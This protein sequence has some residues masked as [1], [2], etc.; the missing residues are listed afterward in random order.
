MTLLELARTAAPIYAATGKVSAVLAAGSVGRGRAD[1]YSDLELD[2][3]WQVPPSD[4]D[5]LGVITALGA[6]LIDLWPFEQA[7]WSENYRLDGA[8]VGVSGFLAEWLT[9]CIADV[10]ERA[11]PDVLKQMRLAALNDGIVLHGAGV[12][13]EWRARSRLYPDALAAAVA[14]EW[15]DPDRL[16]SWHQRYA[17][18]ARDEVV[19]LRTLIPRI[20]SMILG[21]LCAVNRV[22]IEHPSF[23]WTAALAERLPLAPAELRARLWAAANGP[24]VDAV[25][26]LDALLAETLTLVERELPS[27]GLDGLRTELGTVRTQ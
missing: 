21:A 18:V 6:E 22:L 24:A 9:T 10:V 15:L 14:T 19:V 7:E 25:P 8:D 12:V 3:Y 17:L 16:G 26:V 4:T 13:D 2:V 20:T 1:A 11:D 23:K 5:R 27:V